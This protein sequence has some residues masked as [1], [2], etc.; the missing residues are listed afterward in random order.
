MGHDLS[1]RSF[2]RGCRLIVRPDRRIVA[3]SIL[4]AA[5]PFAFALIRFVHTG[6]DLRYLWVACGSLLGAVAVMAIA[7][8]SSRRP[9]AVLALSAGA[10]V[11]ATLL[12][13]SAAML[14]GTRLGPGILVVGSAFGFC[15]A[16]GSTLWVLAR[17]R[18]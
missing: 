12:A 11:A 9:Q 6:S 7:R 4:F 18:D 13:V 17:R 15:G 3:L 14:L 1:T 16:V 8:A 5:A 10:F 2:A